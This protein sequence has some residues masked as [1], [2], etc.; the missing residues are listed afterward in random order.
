GDR[1]AVPSADALALA[2]RAGVDLVAHLA[3]ERAKGDVAELLVLP[4]YGRLGAATAIYLVGLGTAEPVE[5]HALRRAGAA[6]ARRLAKAGGH[7]ATSVTAGLG[8]DHLAAF[9]EGVRLG[10]Y[11]Y[12]TTDPKADDPAGLTALDVHHGATGGATDAALRRALAHADAAMLARDLANMP[13]LDKTPAWL[14]KQART[15]AKAAGLEIEVLEP[16]ALAEQ[17][18]GGILAVGSGAGRD[19]GP[20]FIRLDHTPPGKRGG[21]HVVL[22]GKG[23][24]FDSGGLSL[25][26]NE[27]MAAMKTDMSGGAAVIAVLQAAART[28]LPV[29]LTGLVAAAENMPS[30]TA[31][32]PGD[33]IR[34]YGGQTVEVLNTDA[35]GRLVLADALAYA[36]TQIKPDI[37]IDI[38]T[39]TGAIGIALGKRTAG[40]FSNDDALA[41]A[42]LTAA[43][44]AGEPMWRMPLVDDYREDLDSPV[45]DLK[46]IGG[47]FSGGAITA[48]LFLREFAGDVRWAHLDIA[49]AARS[50]AEE[51]ER[52]K[53]ATGFATRTLLRW[54]DGLDGAGAGARR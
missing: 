45:A 11:K 13:S 39:L 23:I 17:G 51:E 29:R 20:R 16:A 7:A 6:L 41:G 27:G 48:A 12:R 22:V 15:A 44:A 46:N 42:L 50:D 37:V 32:R 33:V 34:H 18:F 35:E 31:M 3:A 36:A 14:A 40:L 43:K 19:R 30:G 9:V 24:T 54:L 49:G 1:G 5:P 21:P 38:A 52:S 47:R 10:S 53:G 28:A 25:K 8:E 4:T 2:E 26:P